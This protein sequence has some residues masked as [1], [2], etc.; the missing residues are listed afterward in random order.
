MKI[1]VYS[2]E[3]NQNQS[4][5]DLI[6]EYI[7]M[8]KNY[9]SLKD[10]IIF[11]KQIAKAQ[12][13]DANKAKEEYSKAYSSYMKD[14][15]NICLDVKGEGVNSMEFANLLKDKSKINFFIGGAFG[16]ENEILK[17]SQK[18]ISLSKLTCA[19]KIAKIMLFEQIY[20]ALSILNAHP[21]HK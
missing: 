1:N 16:F 18:V 3:K 7:K 12:N 9:A 20:R 2:I 8:S 15:F 10:K 4:I 21:Y 19:H 14:G 11:S 13:T 5:K 17:K 6:N